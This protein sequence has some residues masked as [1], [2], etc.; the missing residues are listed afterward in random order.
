MVGKAIRQLAEELSQ[1][2]FGSS[3]RAI[4][5]V[6]KKGNGPLFRAELAF[7]ADQA[8]LVDIAQTK[9]QIRKAT[10]FRELNSFPNQQV[11][12]AMRKIARKRGVEFVVER[13][14]PN[15][16]KIASDDFVFGDGEQKETVI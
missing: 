15:K 5:R 8:F 3:R 11:V 1:F 16:K 2:P 13:I 9:I 14:L 6:A 4:G 10:R 12:G 7:V